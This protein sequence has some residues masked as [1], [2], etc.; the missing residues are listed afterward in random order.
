MKTKCLICSVDR[1][2]LEDFEKLEK[3]I[4]K[5]VASREVIFMSPVTHIDQW[6]CVSIIIKIS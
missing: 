1:D 4:S 2:S 5:K 3:E 6:I